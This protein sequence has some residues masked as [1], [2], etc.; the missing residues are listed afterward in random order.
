MMTANH[1]SPRLT[2]LMQIAHAAGARI[3]TTY[4]T[5][6]EVEQKADTSPV[7]DADTAAEAI[8]LDGL[9]TL[10]PGANIIAEEAVAGGAVPHVSDEFYLVDPL[11]GTREFIS[12]N[13]EFTVNIALVRNGVPVAGVVYA[14]ALSR[15]YAGEAGLGAVMAEVEPHAPWNEAVRYEPISCPAMPG[16]GRKAVASRSHRDESTERWL[17]ENHITDTVAA[18]SSLKFCLLA[19]GRAHLYPRF[20]RTMEWDTAAGHAV[21]AAAGGS[22]VEAETGM[23]L[24]YGKQARGFDNPAFIASVSKGGI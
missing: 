12:R 24:V 14:P 1:P 8:I 16:A 5:D 13:G 20:G 2:R 15:I 3:M 19:E 17:T 21:L 4:N 9:R 6:F 22:V 11:D 7:T 23:P 10:D 18:G